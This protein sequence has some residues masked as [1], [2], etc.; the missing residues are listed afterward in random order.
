MYFLHIFLHECYQPDSSEQIN[1]IVPQKV[2]SWNRSS[3][4]LMFYEVGVLKNFAKSLFNNAVGVRRVS[5]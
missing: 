4:W 5:L 2:I 3:R 1:T